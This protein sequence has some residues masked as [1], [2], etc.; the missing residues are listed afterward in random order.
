MIFIYIY[1][2]IYVYMCMYIGGYK[3]GFIPY[4]IYKACDRSIHN[5]P[6][7]NVMWLKG[8]AL[9]N[10]RK[11]VDKRVLWKRLS[12]FTNQQYVST[13]NNQ[14]NWTQLSH[15]ALCLVPSPQP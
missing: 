3:L 9:Q 5:D 13:I 12:L 8:L 15:I 2:Y 14:T 10:F 4:T 6:S 11:F 7:Q 1:I